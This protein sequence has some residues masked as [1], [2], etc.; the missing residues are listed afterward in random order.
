MYSPNQTT[1]DV[2]EMF[3]MNAFQTIKKLRKWFA[4]FGL[5]DVI[6]SENNKQVTSDAFITFYK[7]KCIEV[8]SLR[9]IILLGTE[10]Q[11]L[12]SNRS[13]MT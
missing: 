5:P 6:I 13:K 12:Q 2:S 9:R 10:R 8:R 3:R 11:K 7:N 4:R 1:P